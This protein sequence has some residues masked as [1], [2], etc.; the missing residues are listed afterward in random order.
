MYNVHVLSI[1]FTDITV[2]ILHIDALSDII[3]KI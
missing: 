1:W 3:I 2:P